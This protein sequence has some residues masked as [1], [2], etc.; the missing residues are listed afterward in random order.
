MAGSDRRRHLRAPGPPGHHD[1]D[2]DTGAETFRRIHGPFSFTFGCGHTRFVALH[3]VPDEGPLDADLA[4]LDRTL[5]AA[6]ERH[7]VVLMHM[8]PSMD[9]HLEPHLEW[10]FTRREPEFFALLR[11]HD[12]RLVC[13]AHGLAFDEH[14]HDNVRVVMSAEAAPVCART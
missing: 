11:E 8:P 13:C 6:S 3:A 2:D 12:V 10:G 1:L 9:G 14:L 4:Y 5:A 7:R